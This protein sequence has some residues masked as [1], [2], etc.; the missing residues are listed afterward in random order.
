MKDRKGQ[1]VSVGDTVAMPER[2]WGRVGRVV[3]ITPT[4]VH[5]EWVASQSG[6]VRVRPMRPEEVE[7][8]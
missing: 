3:K 8:R 1:D 6:R 4:K 5:V 7:V 2:K